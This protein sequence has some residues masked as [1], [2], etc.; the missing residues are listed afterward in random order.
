MSLSVILVMNAIVL[1]SVLSFS[2]V[3]NK[4]SFTSDK[5]VQIYFGLLF[6]LT[7]ILLM[8]LNW[9]SES[10]VFYDAR[11]ILYAVVPVLFSPITTLITV[12]VGIAYR[13]YQGGIGTVAGVI[14]ILGTVGIG[15]L[16][17]YYVMKKIK[18]IQFYHIL[19]YGFIVHLFMLLYHF[20]LPTDIEFI[21]TRIKLISPVVLTL[22]PVAVVLSYYIVENNNERVINIQ[23]LKFSEEKYRLI[24]DG[25]PNGIL[26]FD[27]EGVIIDCNVQ[28]SDIMHSSKEELIGLDMNTLPNKDMVK[29]LEMAF[30]GE[31]GYFYDYYT[32]FLSD[33]T[34]FLEVTFTPLYRNEVLIGG[35][36]VVRDLTQ[37]NAVES[38][39]N[40]VT[41][42]DNV[43]GFY[44]R[45]TYEENI[46]NGKFNKLFP[47]DYA[48][49]SIDNFQFY[50][51]T[52]GYEKSEYI[53]RNVSDIIRKH[54]VNINHIYK[55]SQND[56]VIMMAPRSGFDIKKT[57]NQIKEEVKLIK[58]LTPTLVLTSWFVKDINEANDLENMNDVLRMK[59]S[60][61]RKFSKSSIN[62]NYI[63]LLLASLFEKSEREKKHSERVS[64]ISIGIGKALGFD[65]EELN[66][67]RT[68]AIL[69]DIGKINIDSYILEKPDMLTPDE[70]SEIRNH[71]LIG[72]RILSSVKEYED[73]A[74]SVLSHHERWDGKGYPNAIEGEN[75]PVSSRI[76]SIADSY[77]AMV[78]DRPYREALTKKEAIQELIDN[79]GTQFDSELVDVFIKIIANEK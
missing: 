40:K 55:I 9:G 61:I 75:I 43:T 36:G 18:L 29:A 8:N 26:H 48:L 14:T 1:V 22:Y 38:E 57:I 3:L 66:L 46:I 51:D 16:M 35:I 79:K 39:L 17:K 47:L 54:F 24:F 78:N 6:G 25:V 11:T 58:D 67:L 59:I 4:T 60:S 77:D 32:T 53:L 49:L 42:Y 12:I 5:K 63:N 52:M 30:K 21:F 19:I 31:T 37:I 69:H 10:G 33:V 13:V 74:L 70:F 15:F 73:V 71:T 62:V 68:T 2:N 7:A 20:A 64:G 44:N 45:K 27:L 72:Y 41:N 28:F 34:L 50:I 56:F 65:E 23:K 76:I